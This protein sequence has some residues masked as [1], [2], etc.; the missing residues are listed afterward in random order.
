[1]F[2]DSTDPVKLEPVQRFWNAYRACVE[3]HHIPPQRSGYYVRW[4]QEFVEFQPETKLRD[5]SAADIERFLKFLAEQAGAAEWQAK[6]AAYALRLLYEQFLPSYHPAVAGG[7]SIATGEV[8]FRD[9]ILPGEAERRQ[10]PVLQQLRTEVRERHYSYRTETTY[11]EWVRRFLAFHAYA[12]PRQ[13]VPAT[14]IKEYLE[15]LAGVRYVSA[16][17]QN[18]ALNALVFLYGQVLHVPV[19]DMGDF[20]RA[21]RPRR[22]PEVMTRSEVQALLDQLAGTTK[23][24]ALLMYGGGLRLT[25]CQQL[26]VKDVDVERRQIMVREGKGQKDRVTILPEKAVALLQEHLAAVKAQH[27]RDLAAGHGDV[28]IWP[29][30]ARKYPSAA[31]EWGWQ[32]V[33]PARGFSTD[34]RSGAVRRHH[35]H[36]SLIQKAV[37]TAARKAGIVRPVGCHTLRHSFATH[38]LESGSDIRTVQELLGH[39]NVET[40]MIYTHVLNRPGVAPVTSPLD[41]P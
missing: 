37:K 8:V 29:A 23:L 34:P 3:A 4:V 35:Q 39:A 5:R 32:F 1:M 33:F 41:A 6:Q 40:T 21:K 20:Q 11:L 26:R 7:S 2:M 18:Q 19:G 17:T 31:K 13:L 30:L 36:E 25:E 10:G 9:Q 14:A 24:M 38:L 22:V 16:S 15:Y 27:E 12:D 28:F